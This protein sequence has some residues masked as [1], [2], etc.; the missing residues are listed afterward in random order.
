MDHAEKSNGDAPEPRPVSKAVPVTATDQT[1]VSAKQQAEELGISRQAPWRL[2]KRGLSYDQIRQRAS[3]WQE[4]RL[5]AVTS[6]IDELRH[7][8]GLRAMAS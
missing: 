3:E 7:Q 5:R 8:I 4:E 1:E 2:R 6:A